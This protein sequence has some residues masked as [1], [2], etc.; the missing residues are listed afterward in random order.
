MRPRARSWS[1]PFGREPCPTLLPH[2]VRSPCRRDADLRLRRLD[3][4]PRPARDL[5]RA[6]LLR[7]VRRPLRAAHRPARLGG[8][9]ARPGPRRPGP[10]Q[11]RPRGA[12][13]RR[14]RG[15]PARA[16]AGPRAGRG[17]PARPPEDAAAART[18]PAG[19]ARTGCPLCPGHAG[20]SRNFGRTPMRVLSSPEPG[21]HRRRRRSH[22][23]HRPRRK[24]LPHGAH[25]HGFPPARPPRLADPARCPSRRQLPRLWQRAG[26]PHRDEPHRRVAGRVH[27]LP[28]LRAPHLGRAGQRAGAPGRRVLDST[29]KV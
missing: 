21:T 26:H 18:E 19:R 9:A 20:R 14:P 23:H 22:L 17:R 1:L 3:R 25:Q 28:P 15:R 29:R 16:G 7:P 27:L 12:G 8:A 13:R 5:R 24:Q 11:R 6:A 10:D 4:G 2:R